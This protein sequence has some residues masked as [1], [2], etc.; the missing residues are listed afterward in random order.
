MKRWSYGHLIVSDNI[1]LNKKLLLII[2]INILVHDANAKISS[3]ILHGNVNSFGNFDQCLNVVAPNEKFQGQYCLA[4]LQPSV[5]TNNAHLI[6][7]K[8]LAQSFEI[9]QSNFNDVSFVR[10]FFARKSF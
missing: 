6:H 8:S 10:C 1:K 5:L 7:L 3:G 4:Q 9:I 2:I